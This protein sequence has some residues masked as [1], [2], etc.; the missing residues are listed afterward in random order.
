MKFLISILFLTASLF[1]ERTVSLTPPQLDSKAIC[2]EVLCPRPWRARSLRIENEK[3][4]SKE[5]IHCYGHGSAG[6]TLLFGTVEKAVSLYDGDQK[7]CVVGSG[8]VGLT[9]AIELERRGYKVSKIVTKDLY[10]TPSWW[11]GGQLLVPTLREQMQS[12]DQ[13]RIDA[14]AK[15]TY[16]VYNRVYTGE[17]PYLSKACVEKMPAYL[18]D[19]CDLGMR[20]YFQWGLIPQGEAVTLDFGGVLH[21]HYVE[22]ETLFLQ[23]SQIMKELLGEVKRLGIPIVIKEVKDFEE[24]EE[25]VIFNCAGIGA[26]ELANDFQMIKLYGHLL[27]LNG[28]KIDYLVS[29]RMDVEGKMED[30]YLFPKTSFVSSEFPGG[31]STTAVLGGT[32][33]P[34][35]IKD[36]HADREEFDRL[37]QRARYFFFGAKS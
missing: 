1:G 19:K 27:M 2:Q 16:P 30:I 29:T 31:I 36:K 20:K 5:V 21:P 10:D 24:L 7:I 13:E 33:I 14:F 22:Y 4:G 12:G 18:F 6:W 25:Q 23:V 32:F 11:A 26:R 37:L 34:E 28:N 35:N 3:V 8:C 17:H 15:E 9:T